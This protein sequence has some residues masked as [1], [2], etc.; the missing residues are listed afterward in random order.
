MPENDDRASSAAPSRIA[1]IMGTIVLM[2][3]GLLVIACALPLF[4]GMGLLC[5]TGNY[6]LEI[7]FRSEMKRSNRFL[8]PRDARIRIAIEA[9]TLIVEQPMLGWGNTRL[10]WTPDNVTKQSPY[11]EPSADEY[12]AAGTRCLEWDRWCYEN[13]VGPDDGR[14]WLL[15]VWSGE[16]L[17]R[18]LQ[19]QLPTLTRT[20]TWS[21]P[22]HFPE[23]WIDEEAV[24]AAHAEAP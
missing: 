2:P 15:K 18:K 1:Q 10:W 22:V 16:S 5:V 9:G 24:E 3:I 13:Y 21:A 17:A 6:I 20:G 23:E 11:T 7:R 19:K 12:K 14:A 4:G 8:R